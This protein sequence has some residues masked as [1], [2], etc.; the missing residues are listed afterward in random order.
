[1]ILTPR[2]ILLI[3]IL[4][5]SS[6]CQSPEST[7]EIQRDQS[8]PRSAA[9]CLVAKDCNRTM[10]CAHRGYRLHAPEN[11]LAAISDAIDLGVDFVEIDIRHTADNHLV[12]V[13]DTTVDRTTQGTGNVDQMTLEQV[14]ALEVTQQEGEERDDG[15]QVPTFEEALALLL[16][17]SGNLVLDVDMKTHRGDLVAEAITAAGAEEYLVIHKSD[18]VILD[19]MLARNPN[20]ML[21]PNAIDAEAV[22]NWAQ[23]LPL[24]IVEVDADLAQ[25]VPDGYVEAAHQRDIKVFLDVLGLPDVAVALDNDTQYWHERAV[26][27]VD[28]MQT[29]FPKLLMEFLDEAG[30]R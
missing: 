16:E 20:L 15:A 21:M 5:F 24:T 25:N 30:F 1:M 23:E 29:D 11:T 8:D 3:L 7:P 22:E 2:W 6:A 28:V 13:H 17:Q 4:V 12:L 14:R 10:V 18:P 27:G 9:E 19:A 26:T